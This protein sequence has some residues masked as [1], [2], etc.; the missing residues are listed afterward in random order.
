MDKDI[1]QHG[2]TLV[3]YYANWSKECTDTTTPIINEIELEITN[4]HFNLIKVDIEQNHECVMEQDI[5]SVP[6]IKIY[7]DA[8]LKQIIKSNY[9]KDGLIEAIQ[10]YLEDI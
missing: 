2:T 10:S 3:Y 1:L 6:T 4:E 8:E 7:K 9:S 5:T